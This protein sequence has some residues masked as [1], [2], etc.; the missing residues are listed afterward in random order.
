VRIRGVLGA[1]NV[2]TDSYSMR[3]GVVVVPK[4]AVI[5]DGTVIGPT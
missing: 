1:P 5:A 4:H 2:D 3:D